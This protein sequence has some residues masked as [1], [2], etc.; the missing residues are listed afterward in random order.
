MAGFWPKS[1]SQ[2]HDINGKPLIGAKAYFYVGGT[3]TPLD[4]YGAYDLGD[5]NLLPSPVVTD[6]GGYFPSVFFDEADEFYRVRLTT[7]A[8]VL[9]YDTDGIPIIGPTGGGGGGSGS[10]V[11]PNALLR[12]GD[13]YW[14]YGTGTRS[15]AV[16]M[17]GRTIGSASSGASER[18]NSDVQALYEYLW[19]ADTD[20]AV[21]GGRGASASADWSANK[22]LTL[23]DMRGR[24]PIGL[25]DMGNIAAGVVSEATDLGWTG[26]AKTHTLTISEMPSHDHEATASTAAEHRHNAELGDPASGGS[27]FARGSS[28]STITRQTD[29]ANA[30]T[31]TIDVQNTGGGAAHNNLQPS[32]AGTWYMKI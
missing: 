29:F 12:T 4:V 11:D 5:V 23:P 7:A 22:P 30:H 9:I 20:L 15:G 32:I 21:L 19:A 18:A 27:S 24:T 28:A 3:T 25:D 1:N 10:P 14:R 8:G 13:V 26:G 2:V 16:R 6:G 17:N 31:H